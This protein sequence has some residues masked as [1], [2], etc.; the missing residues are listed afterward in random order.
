[1]LKQCIVFFEPLGTDFEVMKEAK[2]E[3][4]AT[5]AVPTTAS[6]FT[7][8]HK[9]SDFID[10]IVGFDAPWSD[11]NRIGELI[12]SLR[13]HFDIVGT[14]SA[15][16]ATAVVNGYARQLL[17]LP[18][19]HPEQL[20]LITN[21]YRLRKHL[22]SQ[23]LS[24]LTVLSQKEAELQ[25]SWR[26]PQAAYFKP[27]QGA[28]SLCVYR[29]LDLADY[30]ES[31]HKWICAMDRKTAN[32][33]EQSIM[34]HISS[35]NEFFLE[36]EIEGELLSVESI[37]DRGN[38]IHLGLLSRIL[39]SENH[40][41]EMGSCF[42]YPHPLRD[43]I[44]QTVE[45]ALLSLNYRHGPTHIE[46]IVSADGQIEIIDF[47][48]RIV[49]AHVLHSINHAYNIKL[50]SI[51]LDL[52]I[53]RR[54][55]LDRKSE[56]YGCLQYFLPPKGVSHVNSLALPEDS[57]V[58]FKCALVDVGNDIRMDEERQTDVI[59]CYL[60]V[61]D[62]YDFSLEKSHALREQVLINNSLPGRF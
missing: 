5:I 30:K 62:S 59:G 48:P 43:K 15:R 6:V 28:G 34:S 16:C 61:T 13:E 2:R 8:S 60:T 26:F 58:P 12:N 22:K 47:N 54:V 49:G 27:V 57:A 33:G 25:T 7:Q 35:A 11:I 18:T 51:L 32:Y 29:C 3:G 41:I 45:T 38:I 42:P 1:M 23:G 31:Y 44:I 55:V 4:Y 52:A 14:Y 56:K 10:C 19:T 46:L 20:T 24:R 40:I 53:G 39:F 37:V 36:E 9:N 21:K 17:N 50:E